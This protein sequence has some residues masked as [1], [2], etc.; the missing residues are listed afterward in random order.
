MKVR[1]AMLAGLV[2]LVAVQVAV[3]EPAYIGAA[4]CKMCHKV[5]YASWEQL[6]H[7][8]A[9]EQLGAEDQGK[10]ECLKCH[11]TG[12]TADMPGV[13]CEA[14]HGPGGDYKGLKVMKDR[15]ASVAAGL[16]LPDQKT[17]EGCHTGAPHDQAAFD[18]DSAKAAGIHE[19]KNPK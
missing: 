11:A 3:A 12:N 6:A 16:L 7:F 13:Q 19:F 1:V 5:E 14:C 8:K 18:Y 9:F 4:K 15:E 10:A 2:V 17:C